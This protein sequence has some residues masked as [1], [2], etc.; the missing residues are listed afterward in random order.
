MRNVSDWRPGTIFA[1]TTFFNS[2]AR[3]RASLSLEASI[4]KL[5]SV[6][7]SLGP[8]TVN[9]A[10]KIPVIAAVKQRAFSVW[11]CF[12]PFWAFLASCASGFC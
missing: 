5:N 7:S 3:L 11:D 9:V 6:V 4:L 12:G 1:R 8:Q 10:W 2:K